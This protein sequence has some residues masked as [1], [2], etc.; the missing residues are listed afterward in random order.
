MKNKS[1][2]VA[3][4][5]NG[6]IGNKNQVPW[7]LG[8]DMKRFKQRRLGN[9]LI[10]G[11]KTFDSFPEHLKPLPG[12]KSIVITRND[13]IQKIEGVIYVSSIEEAFAEAEKLEGEIFVIGGAEI[14]KLALDLGVIDKLYITKVHANIEGDTFYPSSLADDIYS[15]K[16]SEDFPADAKNEYPTTYEVW[17]RS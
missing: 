7:R 15:I 6:V 17:S 3:V 8:E 2:L 12:S 10:M 14:Y 5:D 11:R 4:S 1:I 16:K 9:I 13:Q